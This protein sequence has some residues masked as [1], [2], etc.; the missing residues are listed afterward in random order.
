MCLELSKLFDAVS[1]NLLIHVGFYVFGATADH[2]RRGVALE[3][4]AV[5]FGDDLDVI[6]DGEAEGLAQLDGNN[7]TAEVINFTNDTGGL[8]KIRSSSNLQFISKKY[9]FRLFQ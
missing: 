8:H 3:N 6:T 2:A 5:L 7:D 1:A 4:D 9:V